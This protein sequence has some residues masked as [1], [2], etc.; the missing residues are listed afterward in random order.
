MRWD[1][2]SYGLLI[3][4]LLLLLSYCEDPPIVDYQPRYVV[5]AFT[6]LYTVPCR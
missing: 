4:P 1:R 3:L 5:E 2:F 6:S